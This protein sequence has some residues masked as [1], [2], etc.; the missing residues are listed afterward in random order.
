MLGFFYLGPGG[1]WWR[2]YPSLGVRACKD[3]FAQMRALA[4]KHMFLVADPKIEKSE[5]M[6]RFLGGHPVEGDLW[7]VDIANARF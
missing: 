1:F 2:K 6:A 4:I 5:T 3:T 7:V